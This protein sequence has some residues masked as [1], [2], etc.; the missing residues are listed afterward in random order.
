MDVAKAFMIGL[1]GLLIIGV[2]I[3]I[4]MNSLADTT[5]ATD[6]F[7][8][9]NEAGWV[10]STTYTVLTAGAYGF[11]NPAITSAVNATSGV[12]LLTGNYTIS[13]AGVI[14]NGTSTIE[15]LDVDFNYTYEGNNEIYYLTDNSSDGLVD[16]FSNTST[17][18]ALLGV[19]VII[20]I[21]SIVILVI[22]RFGG[23]RT[24]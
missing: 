11:A 23:G 14:S 12:A 24:F 6:T 1:M 15:W 4:V 22:N 20:L 13:G 19:A 10:N 21:I 16:F 3:L 18:L 2:V 7:T 17:W 5:L 8:V 9:L